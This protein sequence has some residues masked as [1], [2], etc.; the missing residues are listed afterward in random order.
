MS[1]RAL[2]AAFFISSHIGTSFNNVIDVNASD[3]GSV[4]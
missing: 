3:Y 4:V 1:N 2:C